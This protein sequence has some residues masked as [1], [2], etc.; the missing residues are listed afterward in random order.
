MKQLVLEALFPKKRKLDEKDD[1]ETGQSTG[2]K[3]TAGG[4]SSSVD[5]TKISNSEDSSSSSS[6]TKPNSQGTTLS[7][8]TT[9]QPNSEE[10]RFPNDIG[11]YIDRP[12]TEQQKYDILCNVWRP[13]ENYSFPI[14][15]NKRKFHYGWLKIFPWLTYSEKF[16][17][18][19]CLNC[20]LFG[21]ESTIMHNTSKLQRLFKLPLKNWNVA[22]ARFRDHSEKSELHKTATTRTSLFRSYMEKKSTPIEAMLDKV[23]KQQI[24]ENRKQLRPIV[25]AIFL[26]GRQDIALRGHR[27]DAK[28]Y[29]SDDVNPGNF[30]EI[31]KY[32]VICADQ[33]LEEYFKSTP[34]NVTYKS[35]TTQNDICG[36]LI[37]NKITD[38]IREAK[39]FSVLADEAADC[40]NVE[41]LS[42]VVRFVD[43]KHQIREEFLGFVPCKNGLSGEAIANTIQD[44]LRDRGLSI[45]DCRGQGYDGAGN[46]AGRLSGAA[47]R[48]QAVQ[49]KAIYVHCNSH[50]LNLCVASCCKEL[51]VSN[52]MEHVRVVS[53]FFNFSPKRFELLVKTI[54]EMLPNAN[55]KRLINVCK[56][57][58]VARIDGLDVFIEVFTAI[59][60]CFEIIK[61]NIDDTWNP[62]SVKKAFYLFHA[63]VSFS[64]IAPLVF[65]SRCLEVTRPLTVQLQDSAL[66]AGSAREK[67][68]RLYV[69][70]E[71][72]RNE[73]DVR[74][75]RWFEEAESLAGSVGT[76]P[77]KPRT[78]ERQRH[79]P[80]TPADSPSE[81]Y[82]RVVTIPF[83]DHLKSQI[84]TRFS[85]NNLNV[86]DAVYGLPQNVLMYPDWQTKF[87]KFLDMYKHDLPQPCFLDTELEMWSQRCQME[88]GPL[89][90]KLTDV[91]P[92]VD[93]I[94]FP[95]IYTAFQ[96][97]ATIPVTSCTCERSISVLR[98]LKTYLRSTMTETRLKGLALLNVHREIH[99]DTEEVIDEFA[100]RNPRR[101]M[102]KLFSDDS[103]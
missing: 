19:F 28:Y 49:D 31:L 7:M 81:Y 27:D 96:I 22:T 76:L 88:K 47:A 23:R 12:L 18:A 61:A 62:D 15:E 78:V 67:V 36:Q 14:N 50:I 100:I 87:S 51:L 11:N 84:Q 75:T 10:S 38:E 94:S 56:T 72:V 55:H 6:F 4:S 46:M 13:S 80:N 33:S 40:A 57:R 93:K 68:S 26:C 9:T 48:I 30:I 65:V 85:Q 63:T 25:H 89:P 53:E 44:F 74:H 102:L 41:Q 90:S 98:R 99:L 86:M 54:E 45:D 83:L 24:E 103:S 60:R 37:T 5:T 91:L 58:W 16:D 95:N 66:D 35:K 77:E 71:K 21:S 73:V 8:G 32:G 39:F 3:L 59:V 2:Q 101:M 34:K 92:F 79:R 43:S 52:M 97:F 20:V 69:Q 1:E 17:G 42:L 82:R 64:F 70:L 29:L